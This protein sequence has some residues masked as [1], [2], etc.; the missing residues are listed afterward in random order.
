MVLL[1][2]VILFTNIIHYV[3]LKYSDK[4]VNWGGFVQIVIISTI[5]WFHK[6]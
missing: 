2:I 4:N 6:Q 1:K 5:Y 3:I